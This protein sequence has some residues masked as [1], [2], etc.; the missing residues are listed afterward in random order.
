[1]YM[2]LP[3]IINKIRD[4]DS[5]ALIATQRIVDLDGKIMVSV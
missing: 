2:E 5:E 1:M 4:I 3:S